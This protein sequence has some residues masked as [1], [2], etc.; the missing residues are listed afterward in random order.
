MSFSEKTEKLVNELIQAEYENACKQAKKEFGD[1]YINKYHSLYEGY[2]ILLEEI[3]EVKCEISF[4]DMHQK[5]MW[6]SVKWGSHIEDSVKTLTEY[7]LSS[8]KELAQVGAVLQKIKNTLE[9]EE[10]KKFN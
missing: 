3:E 1:E 2:S 4:L 5:D 6:R 8:I 7:T 9:D 10:C